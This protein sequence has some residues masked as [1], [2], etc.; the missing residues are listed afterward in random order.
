MKSYRLRVQFLP[1]N[2]VDNLGKHSSFQATTILLTLSA[3]II[4]ARIKPNF[5]D[6]SQAKAKQL[7]CMSVTVINNRSNVSSRCSGLAVA[8]RCKSC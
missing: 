8:C 1:K 6:N 7:L 5:A 2:L 4:L 3:G